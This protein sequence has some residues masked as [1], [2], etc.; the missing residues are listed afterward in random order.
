VELL[1]SSGG[2]YSGILQPGINEEAILTGMVTDVLILDSRGHP[3]DL[4][5]PAVG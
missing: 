1:P 4:S 3:T 5:D 2:E